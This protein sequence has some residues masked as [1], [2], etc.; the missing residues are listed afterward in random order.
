MYD[1][2]VSNL[3]A[4][5]DTALRAARA[6]GEIHLDGLTRGLEVG[7]KSG[8]ADLV[9]DVDRRAE[10]RMREVLLGE[11]PDHAILGEEGG[12]S[13]GGRHRWV[14]DPLDGT[15]NY[16]HGFP[17][18]CASVA[19]EV[20]GR[21]VVG[22]VLDPLRDET[23]AAVRGE[24]ATLNGRPLR[25]S[26]AEELG[27]RALLATGF[28]YDAAEAARLVR[29]FARFLELGV[30]VRRPGAAALDL[31]YVAA[32][33]LDGFWEHKLHPWDCAAGNL[34]VEEAGGRVTDPEGGPYSHEGQRVVAT[35]G[36]I[37]DAILAV[38]REG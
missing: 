12:A 15:V 13:G 27:G 31:C 23:F 29:T 28:P 9:T 36:R 8:P 3:R 35:N 2:A 21:P 18:F 34:I 24:G 11:H 30:P 10:A 1:R 37:H 17:F 19:L 16:A 6:A 14:V 20:D 4:Y 32:G 38:L 5:L 22:V 7:T 25:V 26:S 33:R